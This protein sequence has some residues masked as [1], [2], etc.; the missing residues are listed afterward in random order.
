LFMLMSQAIRPRQKKKKL[1]FVGAKR[2][3][4]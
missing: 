2:S 4:K 3:K 1:L